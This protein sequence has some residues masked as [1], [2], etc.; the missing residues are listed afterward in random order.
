MSRA[1]ARSVR[2]IAFR[3]AP[4]LVLATAS[5][6]ALVGVRR[7][8]SERPTNQAAVAVL[9]VRSKPELTPL[10]LLAAATREGYW[11]F[12][13][14]YWTLRERKWESGIDEKYWRQL[15]AKCAAT[16]NLD[17][18]GQFDQLLSGLIAFAETTVESEPG[19]RVHILSIGMLNV[20][21]V[22]REVDGHERV[23]GGSLTHVSAG[24]TPQVIELVATP[25]RLLG[26]RPNGPWPICENGLF[27]VRC[28][29]DGT[30]IAEVRVA[31]DRP[32]MSEKIIRHA[33]SS[34]DWYECSLFIAEQGGLIQL[35]VRGSALE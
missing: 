24:G 22:T 15:A 5:V 31:T 9:A 33:S 10:D 23:I 1:S 20:G 21:A 3:A 11:V 18:D 32:P 8:L 4:T 29:D 27:A 28:G 2:S 34:G 6:Y 30:T 26:Q 13:G 7:M 19:V 16:E 12:P 14:A 17:P 35:V 25:E